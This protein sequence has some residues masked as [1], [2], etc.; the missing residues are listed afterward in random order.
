MYLERAQQSEGQ[1]KRMEFEVKQFEQRY[2]AEVVLGQ[3]L[4]RGWNETLD[5][6][7]KLEVESMYGASDTTIG[8][9]L[10]EKEHAY[11]NLHADFAR[12]VAERDAGTSAYW[13]R[14]SVL[15]T[16][17][18]LLK[19]QANTLMSQKDAL[20]R[21]VAAL[22][23]D[24]Q[25]YAVRVLGARIRAILEDGTNTAGSVVNKQPINQEPND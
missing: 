20:G 15:E 7:A 4:T 3:E 11:Q 19:A 22:L 2:K 9:I 18:Q 14:V 21:E 24:G 1:E 6:L 5:K 13:N 10:A 25:V 12:V 23:R 17:V 16:E 8:R